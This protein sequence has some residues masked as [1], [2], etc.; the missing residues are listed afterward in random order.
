MISISK[1]V[2]EDRA[3]WEDLFRG[4][5]EFYDRT[6]PPELY[7]RA[8]TAFQD[9]TRTHALGARLGDTL[10]GITH[11]LT[12]PSTTTADVCYL[13]DL[14]TAADARGQGVATALIAAVTEWARLRDCSRVYWLTAET[15]STARGLY[16]QVAQYRGFIRYEINL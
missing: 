4:Y 12:H 11:F 15:N 8:W 14:F 16:D 5:N 9:D 10:V 6:L 1:L 2:E 7:D 3:D 13:Q